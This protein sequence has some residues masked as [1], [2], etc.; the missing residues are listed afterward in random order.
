MYDYQ[1]IIA[2][3]NGTFSEQ[4]TYYTSKL[5]GYYSSNQLINNY[6]PKVNNK[7]MLIFEI[8]D[9][10]FSNYENVH[11][12][13]MKTSIFGSSKCWTHW[14]CTQSILFDVCYT[15]KLDALLWDWN[16]ALTAKA[17]VELIWVP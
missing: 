4:W 11:F 16:E 17:K 13:I 7:K 10:F 15:T 6:I 8:W 3:Q 12:N 9:I 2:I 1:V 5:W 14:T